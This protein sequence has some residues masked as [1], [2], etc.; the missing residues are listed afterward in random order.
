LNTLGALC[1]VKPKKMTQI[2]KLLAAL[3]LLITA[4]CTPEE[5]PKLEVNAVDPPNS[6]LELE[7]FMK[8]GR[9]AFQEF[10][11]DAGAAQTITGAEGTIFTIPANAFEHP[12]GQAISGNV[13]LR[14][15]EMYSPGAM[16]FNDAGTVS[17][18]KILNS[19]G[20][21]ELA[22]QQNGTDVRLAPNAQIGVG[23]PTDSM[24][25]NM[26]LFAANTRDTNNQINWQAQD[27][28]V[29]DTTRDSTGT[30]IDS[31]Y[32]F[33]LRS[34]FRFINCDY[35]NTDPR[36]LTEVTIQVGPNMTRTDTRVL[37][38]LPSVNAMV[39]V[40]NFSSPNFLINGGYRLP[41]GINAV[42]IAINVDN[43]GVYNYAI[44]QNTVTQNHLE[45]MNFSSITQTQLI[46][47]LNSL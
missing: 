31:L 3:L 35:F 36:P 16:I 34:L 12:N 2:Q 45:V 24:D 30:A 10:T 33:Q 32:R 26:E 39:P 14:L 7:Q 43:L 44:Q 38:Y 20:S 9:E 11:F 13:T 22:I 46:Q 18:G 27:V 8:A 4:A 47:L 42:F 5:E 37:V 28:N 17:N 41:V 1:N 15:R 21:F 19:S 40:Y 6:K 29:A 23:V 25:A